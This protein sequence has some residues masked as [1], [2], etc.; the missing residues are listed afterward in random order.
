ML[1]YVSGKKKKKNQR[2]RYQLQYNP[3]PCFCLSL[4]A[5]WIFLFFLSVIDPVWFSDHVLVL[6]SLWLKWIFKK[7]IR[8]C[9]LCFGS[10]QWGMHQ[11][12]QFPFPLW[13]FIVFIPS[14]SEPDYF[15]IFNFS[16]TKLERI[17][18]S[19]FFFLCVDLAG[20]RLNLSALHI[21]NK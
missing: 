9:L 21:S 15:N 1:P 11:T 17:K 13:L 4:P 20:L 10:I 2:W 16:G 7:Q 19:T 18:Q 5:D 14:S 3:L 6:M 12:V 8:L